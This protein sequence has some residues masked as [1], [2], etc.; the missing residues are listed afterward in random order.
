RSREREHLELV[1]LVDPEDPPRVPPGRARLPP[2]A[3]REPRVAQRQRLLVEDLARVQRSQRHLRGSN[4]V[5]I[6][7]RQAVD[8]LLGVRQERKST[9]LNSSHDQISYAVFC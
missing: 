8:L 7:V 6:V 2:K 5:E 1:E 9:R 3:R 4:Q